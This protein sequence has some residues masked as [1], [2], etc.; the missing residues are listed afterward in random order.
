MFQNIYFL[1]SFKVGSPSCPPSMHNSH[2]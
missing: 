2:R 1:N